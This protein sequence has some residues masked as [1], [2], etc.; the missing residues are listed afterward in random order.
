VLR[1][2]LV[3]RR[4]KRAP[5]D[6]IRIV[7]DELLE[8]WIDAEMEAA[9]FGLVVK[10]VNERLPETGSRASLLVWKALA[11]AGLGQLGDAELAARTALKE[12]PKLETAV[13]ALAAILQ[14]GGRIDE[15]LDECDAF[16]AKRPRCEE[17]LRH[18]I[19]IAR[20]SELYDVVVRTSRLYITKF[21]RSGSVLGALANA[22]TEFG[23]FAKADRAYRQAAKLEPN[24]GDHH[25]GIVMLA[26]LRQDDDAA[27]TYLARL[28]NRN[29]I[30]AKRVENA[31]DA[32]FEN[33]EKDS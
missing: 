18:K 4:K 20:A 17:V 12:D 30:L 5:A 2:T 9:E 25:F 15:A 21:G 23:E 8:T 16:L 1:S 3:A 14:R 29:R 22:Y 13:I 6:A 19:D 11:H 33:L 26:Y 27:V 7:D 24:V 31:V 32:F 28:A 10:A